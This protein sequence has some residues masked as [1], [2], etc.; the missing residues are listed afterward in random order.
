MVGWKHQ[1]DLLIRWTLDVMHCEMNFA[2]NILKTIT[3]EKDN[4]KVR[5]D[6]QHRDIR[7]HLWFTKNPK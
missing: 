3:S 7:P 2:K 4:I 1:Q 5:F 6:L